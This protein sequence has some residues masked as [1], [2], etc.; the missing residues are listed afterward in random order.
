M[1][2]CRAHSL[3]SRFAQSSEHESGNN[4]GSLGGLVGCCGLARGWAVIYYQQQSAEPAAG[5]GSRLTSASRARR[6]KKNHSR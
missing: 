4:G 5:E 6:E 2:S 1:R 3:A